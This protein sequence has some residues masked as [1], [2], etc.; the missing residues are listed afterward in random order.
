M[1]AKEK[2]GYIAKTC[3][4]SCCMPLRHSVQFLIIS[5]SNYILNLINLMATEGGI[6]NTF[7]RKGAANIKH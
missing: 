1:E 5:K 4:H 2:P 3:Y 7:G 6:C